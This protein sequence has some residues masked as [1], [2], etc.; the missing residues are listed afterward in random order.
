MTAS[1]QLHTLRAGSTPDVVA[2]VFVHRSPVG[3][4][5]G[6]C[7]CD[8]ER[9]AR[10]LHQAWHHDTRCEDAVSYAA[11]LQKSDEMAVWWLQPALN[12]DEL[13]DLRQHARLV[14]MRLQGGGIPYA[15]NPR[16]AS[17]SRQGAIDLRDSLGLTCATLVTR[18]FDAARIPLIDEAT[19]DQRNPERIEEDSA[20]Q[21]KLVEY[22]RQ[23]DAEHASRVER[24]V[25][26]ARVRAE[27]VAVA[28]TMASRPATLTVVEPPGRALV[29]RVNS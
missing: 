25:G 18:L 11:E 15:L 12:D 3:A 29:A 28:S 17:I 6:V 26:C 24:D 7:F 13:L 5:V 21:R 23:Q 19:W 9:N 10:L 22:L 4:H 2:A 20:A 1:P 8:D 14:A 16:N 27:E